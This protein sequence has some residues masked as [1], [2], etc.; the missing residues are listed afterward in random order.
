MISILLVDDE[1]KWMKTL[2]RTLHHHGITAVEYIHMAENG[3][4]ALD[5]LKS[6]N[7]D[8]IFLDLN[9]GGESGEDL[10]KIFKEL[11][12]DKTVVIMTGLTAVQ[13]AINCIKNGADDY[14]TKTMKVDELIISIKRIIKLKNLERENSALKREY[15]Q[16]DA[17]NSAFD[18]FVTQSPKMHAIFK[19]LQAIAPST[20]PILITGESGVGKGV[21]A[22]AVASISRPDKPFVSLNAAGL[23][24]Q[25]F[26]DTLFGHI[27]G[28]Y[29]D[30]RNARSGMIA[31]AD[32][33]TVFLDEIG[34]LPV[35]SQ[36][37]LLYLT[38]DGEYQP[39][40]SDQVYNTDARFIFATNQDMQ[41]K[42][43]SGEFR[44]DLYFR[45]KTHHVH[46]PPLRERKEDV[47][48]LFRH[49]MR[50]V[51]LEYSMDLPYVHESVFSLL[52]NYDFP[53]NTRQLKAIVYDA[54]MKAEDGVLSVTDFRDLFVGELPVN[55]FKPIDDKIP[56]LEEAFN[57]LVS[58]AMIAANGNQIKAAA[59]LGISQSTLS[60]RLR[61]K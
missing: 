15:L 37:K 30:A 38:Q 44:K 6:E 22:K 24:N 57:E 34:E 5:I 41:A 7:I 1:I 48:V 32:G 50:A 45:L 21:L 27:K 4:Q 8:L 28:A 9:M 49:F 14:F 12:P 31:Q 18:S 16:S 33:G 2:K 46:I 42:Q 55:T 59:I 47:P 53:G 39:L 61:K 54:V 60:R 20:Q 29:T 58:R 40:G 52:Q 13:P 17:F 43:A 11:Y 56:T 26:S 23:D 35:Q 3:R 19:Y 36:L 51:S 10:L 25:M